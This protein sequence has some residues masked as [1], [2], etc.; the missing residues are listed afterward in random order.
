MPHFV[1]NISMMFNEHDFLD[2]FAAAAN[3]GFKAVEFLFPYDYEPGELKEKLT[4]SNL[5]LALFNTYPGDWDKNERGLASIPGRE[6]DFEKAVE[7]A[8]E[9]AN[10]LGNKHI[11]AMSGLVP[12]G[13]D[14]NRHRQTLIENL[15]RVVPAAEKAGKVLIIEPINTRDI[16]NYFLNF[17]GQA[18]SIIEDVGSENVKLQFDLYHCQIMEGDLTFHMENSIDICA[19]MQIAGTPGRHEP[20]VGEVNYPYLFQL[21]D[22]LGYT[23][24]VGCEYRPKG[25]TEEGLTWFHEALS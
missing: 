17:Q 8:L 6:M 2:R 14:P 20:N 5:K 13:G 7:R 16:P 25:T 1:A 11:H 22:N 23:G 15:K 18:R 4:E 12:P 21:M 3:S 10:V 19:H 24:W 9:Y